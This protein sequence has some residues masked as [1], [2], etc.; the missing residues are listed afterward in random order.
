[1]EISGFAEKQPKK[2]I[3]QE[4]RISE[5]VRKRQE[6]NTEINKEV[7][8]RGNYGIVIGVGHDHLGRLYDRQEVQAA[9]GIVFWRHGINGRGGD[10]GGGDHSAG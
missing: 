6:R 5:K 10:A 7:F 9:A 3:Q 2:E 8:I 1:M 4:Q